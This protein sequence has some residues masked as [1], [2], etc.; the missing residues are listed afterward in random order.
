MPRKVEIRR[1]AND[2]LVA[3]LPEVPATEYGQLAAAV[4]GRFRLA[5]LGDSVV[6]LDEVFRDYG[7]GSK[8]IGIEWDNWSGFIVVAKTP[9]SEPLVEGIARYLGRDPSEI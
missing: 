6:G 2:R 4:A 9:E 3:S 5:A 1:D 7:R 8:R